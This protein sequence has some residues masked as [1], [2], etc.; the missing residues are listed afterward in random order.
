MGGLHDQI[1]LEK[2]GLSMIFLTKSFQF[3][4]FSTFRK[5]DCFEV[6]GSVRIVSR[7]Y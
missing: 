2:F 4:D 3:R 6:N 1:K 7:T 5:C